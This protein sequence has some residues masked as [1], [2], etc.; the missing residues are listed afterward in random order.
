M[1]RSIIAVLLLAPLFAKA[2]DSAPDYRARRVHLAEK[3]KGGIAI[4]FAAAEP[5][6]NL[7]SYRQDSDF[8]YLTGWNQPFAALYIQSAMAAEDNNPE[9][10]YR[11][12]LFLPSRNLRGELYTGVKLDAATPNAPAITHV[13][14][15]KPMSELS[16]LLNEL[17]AKERGVLGRIS[18]QPDSLQAQALATW[19]AATIGSDARPAI[20]DASGMIGELRAFKDPFEVQA[21][22]KAAKVSALAHQALAKSVDAG[23][24]ERAAAAV[25]TESIMKQGCERPAYPPI[26]G[27]GVNSTVLHYEETS[28][29]MQAGDVIVVD[30]AAECA[31]YASDLTRTLPV[32]GKFN[33]RQQEIY[34]IVRGAQQAAIDGFVAGKSRIN[35]PKHKYPDSLDTI[36]FNYMNAHGKD[37]KGEPLGKYFIHGIGHS[38]GIDVHDPWDYTK[39]IEKGMVFT[40]E[41]GIY[42]P[43]EKIGVRIE[44]TF[45][46]TPEGKLVSLTGSDRSLPK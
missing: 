3:L 35:D 32:S 7:L 20:A 44:D 27:T 43:E 9:R 11:E 33:P 37:L 6:S 26:V 29:T 21:L 19:A 40:I 28:G 46:V 13:D 38:V 36:A 5:R 22:A 25:F 31:M 24:T 10:K 45:Y 12:I 1:R 23:A 16:T 14:E 18:G 2:A 4:L 42:I 15:V 39:P 8:F 30:A 17:A 41:P 34:D